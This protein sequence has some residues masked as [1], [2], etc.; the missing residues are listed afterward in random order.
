MHPPGS[1]TRKNTQLWLVKVACGLFNFQL[2][3]NFQ[4]TIFQEATFNFSSSHC[5]LKGKNQN[6]QNQRVQD[7]TAVKAGIKTKSWRL[8]EGRVKQL[9]SF[10]FRRHYDDLL[11]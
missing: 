7:K 3:S 5:A 2:S 1:Q 11:C 8:G 6:N 10:F 4:P 9:R